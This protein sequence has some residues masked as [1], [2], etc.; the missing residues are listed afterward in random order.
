MTGL[1]NTTLS[2]DRYRR[3]G[4]MNGRCLCGEVRIAVDG[5]YVAAVGICHCLMCRRWSGL[6]QAGFDVA[7]DAVTITGRTARFAASSIAERVFCA[8]CGSHLWFRVSSGDDDAPYEFVPGI[9][10]GADDFPLITEAYAD[11]AARHVS[12]DGRHDRTTRA[13]YETANPH[14]EGDD[15]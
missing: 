14:V 11:R 13:E 9:F 1:V 7:A 12:L 2:L 5:E 4:R 15:P 10:E 3:T 8:T 6:V